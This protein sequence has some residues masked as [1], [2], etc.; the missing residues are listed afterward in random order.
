MSIKNKHITTVLML[1]A[2][3]S[4]LSACHSG[5]K[6]K[7]G[8]ADSTAQPAAAAFE[9]VV[10]EKGILSTSL[11]VPGE[12]V[13]YQ[14]VDLYAKVNSYVKKM[15]VD[16]GSEVQ[17]GQLL[18]TLEAP[19]INSQLAGAK[20]RIAQQQAIYLASKANYDRLLST[21][22][23]PGTISQND[24]D[25]AEA[26][27]NADY[28]NVEA[29][30]SASEE[31]TAN[32]NYLEIRAPFSGV[33]TA[34]NVNLGAYVGPS[35]KGSDQPLLVLQ[36]QNKLRLVIS[37]PESS[38]GGLSTKDEVSFTVRALPNQ[39]F[40]AKVARLA[41]ALDDKLRSERLEMDVLNTTKKLLPGMYAEVNLPLPGRDSA[42]VIPK[43][44]LVISTEKVFVIRVVNGKA[45]WVPVQKGMQAGDKVEVHGDLKA[46]DELIKSA[47]DEIRDGQDIKVAE[48]TKP[49]G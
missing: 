39:K 1:A 47:N 42:F 8:D 45:Q 48:G 37:I 41:G 36:Q 40:T 14:Q 25:Q 38:T 23:T 34:R 9:V 2:A 44:A 29:A 13:P 10:A 20:S 17:A 16:V 3:F 18:V 15:L 43:T 35:G 5:T 7:T 46:G 11:Q 26:R 28:A 22:K 33:I 24:L 30:K 31:I 4:I 6:E 12:L 27:K 49:K 32:R 19:E 21:S